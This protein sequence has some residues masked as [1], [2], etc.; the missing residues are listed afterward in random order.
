VPSFRIPFEAMAGANEVVLAMDS[1][2]QAMALAEAAMAEVRR[3]E[4]KYSRYRADSILSR[5][6]A[7]AAKAAVTVDDETRSLLDY[8]D[9][10]YRLSDGLF[11]ITSG[12]LRRAWNFR[13]PRLPDAL[14]LSR[15]VALIGWPRVE[16]DGHRVR[17]PQAGM[18]LDF[19]G[20]GKEYAADRAG[21]LLEQRG[22]RHGY[23]NL[24]GDIR[25]IG[26]RPDGSPWQFGIQHPRQAGALVATL[27]VFQGGLATSGDYERYFELDGQRYC[28]ILDPRSGMPVAHWRTVSVVA[29]L[30]VM[31]GNG[32]TIA[33][34]KQAEGLAFLE[35]SGLSYLAV[36]PH[37]VVHTRR[38][39]CA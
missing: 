6:N 20:F 37:G 31:A 2:A 24:A 8:A 11:D 39:G 7:A 5:I 19:G 1:E 21:A 16:R 10:L 22:A 12:I 32:S 14:E 23:V 13:Q 26:P 25:V 18:E 36:D 15:L 34:L 3:V 27:P 9:Q 29:P 33:M 35:A 30:A 38:Q 28:H 4:A 17:L